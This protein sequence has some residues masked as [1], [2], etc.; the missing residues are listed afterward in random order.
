M[1]DEV[2]AAQAKWTRMELIK[3]LVSDMNAQFTTCVMTIRNVSEAL[4]D[5]SIAHERHALWRAK[6]NVDVA[7]DKA[8]QA[9]EEVSN[10]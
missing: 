1:T 2:R 5:P 10:G 6:F 9:Q 4:G 7:I 3:A 8:M